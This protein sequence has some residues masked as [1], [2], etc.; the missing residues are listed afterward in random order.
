MMFYSQ[1]QPRLASFCIALVALTLLA[2]SVAGN[3]TTVEQQQADLLE[4]LASAPTQLDGGIAEDAVWQFWF[5]QSP[6]TQARDLLDAAIERREA[7]DFEAA[8]ELLTKLIEIAPDFAEGYNQRAFVR[9]LRERFDGSKSDLEITLR[10]NPEHFGAWAGLYHIYSRGGEQSK[11]FDM[12]QKA[13]TIH[14]WLKERGGLPETKWPEAYRKIHE[15]D[16]SI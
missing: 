10:M 7:Y 2:S 8:E 12:L 14:P 9:F 16:G 1:Y 15:A 5:D 13:V 11:A 3:R 4:A 6:T